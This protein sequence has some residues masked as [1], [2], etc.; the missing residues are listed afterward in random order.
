MKNKTIERV[1]IILI[2]IQV[3]LIILGFV[4]YAGKP[5]DVLRYTVMNASLLVMNAYT[6]HNC[7]K[8]ES[9]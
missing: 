4:L 1:L 7:K 5:F 2:A 8:E 6:L 3:V 9:K